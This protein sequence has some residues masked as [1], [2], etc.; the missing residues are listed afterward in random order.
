MGNTLNKLDFLVQSI[1]YPRYTFMGFDY[2]NF[3]LDRR[4]RL[5]I[6]FDKN[7]FLLRRNENEDHTYRLDQL[8]PR[9]EDTHTL[10]TRD[11]GYELRDKSGNGFI[12]FASS[13]GLQIIGGPGIIISGPT[14]LD[15]VKSSKQLDKDPRDPIGGHLI[16]SLYNPETGHVIDGGRLY[17][18]S[19]DGIKGPF[20]VIDFERD[21]ELKRSYKNIVS[22]LGLND[23]DKKQSL[24]ENTILQR[25]FDEFKDLKYLY[26]ENPLKAKLKEIKRGLRVGVLGKRLGAICCYQAYIV[27]ATIERLIVDGYLPGKVFYGSGKDHGWPLY[28]SKNGHIYVIDSTQKHFTNLTEH[29]DETFTG[30][31]IENNKKVKK[32]FK[33]IDFLPPELTSLREKSL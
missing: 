8:E 26:D 31:E 3:N 11:N 1:C 27:C 28:L 16:T 24:D 21:A 5:G 12:I 23:P 17:I 20:I 22:S 32:K 25:V 9:L 2:V 6:H 14:V 33:Y 10:T 13:E 30:I 15:D 29:P 7:A 19:K 18:D 4:Q